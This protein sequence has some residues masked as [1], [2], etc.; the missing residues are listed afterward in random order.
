M[1]VIVVPGR[2]NPSLDF[3]V[4]ISSPVCMPCA[5]AVAANITGSAS[6]SAA[7]LS[8]RIYL[9]PLVRLVAA[10]RSQRTSAFTVASCVPAV[11]N[12]RRVQIDR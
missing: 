2:V 3:T 12:V 11:T 8:A 1:A 6:A 9:P 10:E 5:V 7:C 4:P